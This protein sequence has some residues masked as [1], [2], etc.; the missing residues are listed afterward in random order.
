MTTMV[1]PIGLQLRSAIF[2]AIAALVPACSTPRPYTG[3][4]DAG[5]GGSSGGS[6]HA[7]ASDSTGGTLGTGGIATSGSGGILGT[8]GEAGHLGNGGGVGSGGIVPGSGGITMNQGGG[9]GSGGVVSGVAGSGGIIGALGGAGG[10][11]AGSGGSEAGSGGHPVATGGFQGSAGKS[12]SGGVMSSGGATGSGGS[13]CSDANACGAGK[14]CANGSCL[15]QLANGMACQTM[16]QCTSGNCTAG[17]CCPAGLTNCSGTCVDLTSDDK[18][19]GACTGQSVDCTMS[20]QAIEHC[21]SGAC[22]LVDGSPCS[23]DSDCMS[24]KCDLFYADSDQDGYP[25]HYSTQR[26]CTIPGTLSSGPYTT[27][28]MAARTDGKWDCCDQYSPAHPDA[29]AF[30][31]WQISVV[32]DDQCMGAFGDTNCNG[33]VEVDPAAV[34]TTGCNSPDG[35]VCNHM[36]RAPIAAD[37]GMAECG[38]GAPSV[39]GFCSLYCAPSGPAVSCR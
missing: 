25:N 30:A 6:G 34:I 7:G 24:A 16:P 36:T 22:R 31:S 29:T 1:K 18:H 13:G 27:T 32:L 26:F 15:S 21:R 33:Q 38:C 39:G 19:C 10:R 28:F 5:I 3:A 11:P 23:S 9:P 17:L 4:F 12:G 37:C 8:G 2:A 35:T 14:Y 20:G